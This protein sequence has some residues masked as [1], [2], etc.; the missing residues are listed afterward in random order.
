MESLLQFCVT[1]SITNFLKDESYVKNMV[2]M[3]SSFVLQVA[4][5]NGS[6]YPPTT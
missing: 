6:M 1:K 5:K 2:D 3:L 4:N